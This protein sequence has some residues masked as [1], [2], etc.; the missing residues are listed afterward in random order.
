MAEYGKVAFDQANKNAAQLSTLQAAVNGT[1]SQTITTPKTIDFTGK[2]TKTP[3]QASTIVF[4]QDIP[5]TPAGT[6]TMKVNASAS[7]TTILLLR[8]TD[9][10]TLKILDKKSI[11]LVDGTNVINTGFTVSGDG[12]EYIGFY[13]QENLYYGSYKTTGYYETPKGVDLNGSTLSISKKNIGAELAVSFDITTS[14]LLGLDA[15]S[16]SLKQDVSDI[17]GRQFKSFPKQLNMP[18]YLPAKNIVDTFFTQAYFLGRWTRKT[19]NSTDCMYTI[20][21]GASFF[22]KVKG[23]TSVSL[24]FLNLTNASSTSPAIIAYS[25]DGGSF[26]R[27]TVG[28]SPISITG[29][30]TNEHYIRV[31]VVGIND[32]DQVWSSNEGVAFTGITVD[33]GGTAEPIKPKSRIGMFFGD[34]IAAGCWVL[35]KGTNA[36]S[37]GAEQNY[38]AQ[39]C[40]LLNAINVRVAFSAAGVTKGGSGGVPSMINYIDKMDANTPETS[41][42]PDFIVVNI[43]TND[44]GTGSTF[45]TPLQACIDRIQMKYPGVVIFLMIP[46]N[47]TKLTETRAVAIASKNTVL[48]D[49][50]GWGVTYTDGIHPDV[51]GSVTGG[52]KLAQFLLDYFGKPYFMV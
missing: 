30:D 28:E 4:V 6:V 43:G 40:S 47:G 14:T 3:T 23:T 2:T 37:H 33:A 25:V 49:T 13:V 11:T 19:I 29:L 36:S 32:Q 39:C 44:S 48:V 50:T 15:K 35:N 42:L 27:K 12:T 24:N 10:S 26:V 45:Q 7:T 16:N 22:T 18:R 51:A 21:M 17:Q 52:T 9:N 34:S 38:V 46:F 31:V 8:K 5:L 41:D 20:N 1:L